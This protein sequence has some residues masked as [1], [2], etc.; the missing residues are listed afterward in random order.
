[1]VIHEVAGYV[2]LQVWSQ[3]CPTSISLVSCGYYCF[4]L[5]EWY[6]YHS[7]PS[8]LYIFKADLASNIQLKYWWAPENKSPATLFV[9]LYPVCFKSL[10][11]YLFISQFFLNSQSYKERSLWLLKSICACEWHCSSPKWLSPF[12]VC[13]MYLFHIFLARGSL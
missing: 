6:M 11:A 10:Q 2:K 5:V 7:M 3:N 8:E 12:W 13:C 1:M 9:C 4:P